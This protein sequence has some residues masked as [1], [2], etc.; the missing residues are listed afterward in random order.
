MLP[1]RQIAP[2]PEI[3][4]LQTCCWEKDH[5]PWQWPLS[6][7][8]WTDH[9]SRLLLQHRTRTIGSCSD[10]GISGKAARSTASRAS[11]QGFPRREE[12]SIPLRILESPLNVHKAQSTCSYSAPSFLLSAVMPLKCSIMA[13][14]PFQFSS[15][16]KGQYVSQHMPKGSQCFCP[17]KVVL[18]LRASESS[19]LE[20]ENYWRI[21]GGEREQFSHFQ[22]I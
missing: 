1:F 4:E 12:Q 13:C 14:G 21:Q 2:T 17:R 3:T 11:T 10:S 16:L 7:P 6:S 15:A 20:R 19:S 8:E 5:S 22:K 18:T 9:S